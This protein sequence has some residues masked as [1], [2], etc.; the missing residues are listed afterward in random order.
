MESP[1]EFHSLKPDKIE[2]RV[3]A[4][5]AVRI[6]AP[7]GASTLIGAFVFHGLYYTLPPLVMS[8]LALH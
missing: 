3:R 1:L 8:T 5:S 4:A 2:L 7:V 6:T